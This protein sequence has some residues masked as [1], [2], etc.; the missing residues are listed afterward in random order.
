MLEKDDFLDLSE[1][2]VEQVKKFKEKYFKGNSSHRVIEATILDSLIK[3]LEI[4]KRVND[5]ENR[6]WFYLNE[7]LSEKTFNEQPEATKESIAKSHGW[8]NDL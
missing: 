4:E 5:L 8:K 3:I 6:V 7:D 1:M 2:N